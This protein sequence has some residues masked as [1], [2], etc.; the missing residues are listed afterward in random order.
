MGQPAK[1]V[2]APS[3]NSVCDEI[4]VKITEGMA[5][6]VIASSSGATEKILSVS[7]QFLHERAKRAVR[8]FYNLY[9]A[10]GKMNDAK[11]SINS[12]VD[13]IFEAAQTAINSGKDASSEIK[14]DQTKKYDRLSISAIQKELETI[15]SVDDSMKQKLVPILSSMQF[16]DM[17]KHR[18]TNILSIIRTIANHDSKGLTEKEIELSHQEILKKLTSNAERQQF[19]EI[20]LKKSPP[21]ISSPSELWFDTIINPENT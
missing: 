18:L 16:D 13:D 8:D 1:K 20:V 10:D 14:E 15:I 2:N 9:F 7:G 4:F 12:E 17:L 3:Q 19:Y 21:D 5:E 6:L 11:E